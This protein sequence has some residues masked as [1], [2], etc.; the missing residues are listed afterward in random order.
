MPAGKPRHLVV[1]LPH[2]IPMW[3][4]PNVS[5]ELIRK[6]ARPAFTVHQPMNEREFLKVL[7]AA[8]VLF[9]W[10]LARRHVEK[11]GALRWLHTPLAGVDRVLN[12][13]LMCTD[14]RVTSARGVNAVAVAEHT[15]AMLLALTRGIADAVRAQ[16][17][18]RWTMNELDARVPPLEELDGK[19]MGILGLGAIGRELAVR[20]RAFG[21]QVWGVVRRQQKK[22]DCVDRLLVAGRED[23]VIRK[24]DVLV[25]ALPKTPATDGCIGERQLRRMKSSAILINVGRGSLVQESALIRALREGWIAGAGL[26]VFAE[27]PLPRTSPLWSMPR[28]VVSPHIGGAHP[29]YMPRAAALFID[30]LGRYLRGRTLTNEIDRETGY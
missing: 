24:A 19:L 13:E 1:Y 18:K 21:M 25:L 15:F 23:D 7:P 14:V 6:K 4:L 10:G 27:E 17:D 29:D 9:A 3:R 5:R 12:P 2:R 11:A 28:V 22:P 16:G 20:C 26:D 30:N 8:E